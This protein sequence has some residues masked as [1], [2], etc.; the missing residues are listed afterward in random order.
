MKQTQENKI[1]ILTLVFLATS[2]LPLWSQL[3]LNKVPFSESSYYYG[4][5]N[6][7][8]ANQYFNLVDFYPSLRPQTTAADF[9]KISTDLRL[10]RPGSEKKLSAFMIDNPT[11]YLTETAYYDLAS[12]YFLN[13]KYTYALKWFSKIK[14]TDVASTKRNEYYFN[15]AYTL[16]TIKRFKE[17]EQLFQKIENVPKYQYDVS[18]YLGY[19]AY[20]LD[21]YDAAIENFNKVTTQ[22][23]D[24]TVGYFQADMNFNLGRFEK[25]IALARKSLINANENQTSELSKIIGESY[26]NLEDYRS[27]LP[28]LEVYKGKKG[29]WSNTDFYQLGYTYYRLGDYEKAIMQFNKIISGDD[30]VTQNAYYHLAD[31]YLKTDKK[32]E[33]LN[34]FKS[35]SSFKFDLVIKEDAFLNYARLSYE[36]GNAYENT[37]LVLSSFLDQYPKNKAV[38]EIE[39]LLIDS[40]VNSRNYDGA[41]K[42]LEKKTGSQYNG[43]LQK[44]NYMKAIALFRNGTFEESIT[45]FDRS[46]KKKI[47]PIIEANC[48]YWSALAK[49]ENNNFEEV[50]KDL[51]FF[52]RHPYAQKVS[53]FETLNYHIAYAYFKLKNYEAARN[54][55][56]QYL[57]GSTPNASYKRDSF[58]RMGD[59]DFVLGKYWPAMESYEKAIEL[60]TQKGMYALYQKALSYGFVDRN[61]KKIEALNRL[62]TDYP[63]TS[64]L[65]DTYFEL[66]SAYTRE[67]NT[68]QAIK[69]YDFLINNFPKSP[70]RSR[71]FLNKGLILYNS[72]S[73]EESMLV[74]Q[75]L[76]LEYP[77]EEVARQALKT[78]KEI[79][80]DLA[81]V[82]VFASWVKQLDGV[83]IEENEL[84]RASFRSAERLFNEN[85]KKAALKAFSSYL[86]QYPNGANQLQAQFLFAELNFQDAK[87]ESAV[88]FYKRVIDQPTN[89]YSEQSLVRIT[90]ALV[91][92]ELAPSALRY[93]KTLE[94]IAQFDENKRYALFNLMQLYYE[95][96]EFLEAITYA[97]KI[98]QLKSLVPKIKWDAYRVLAR[99]AVVL[100]DS[101]KASEAYAVLENA[102]D[103]ALAVEALY[104]NAKQK[105]LI[106]DYEGSNQLIEKIAK[107][108]GNFPEWNAK[109]LL[110]MS[111]NFYQL[112][113]AFQASFILESIL[114]NFTQFPKIIKQAQSDLDNIKAIEAQNNSSI[115]VKEENEKN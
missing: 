82:D 21:D 40:Y 73:L 105:H 35:A 29:R 108:F 20:Q 45:F 19:I 14:D 75:K 61:L 2:F 16:F 43:A 11:S 13:G 24:T 15:K 110:L 104:F 50:I 74:L 64:L 95:Q 33:A 28:Y 98:L 63:K 54:S 99:S 59:S 44:L 103:A 106:Y 83:T 48:L 89:E 97:Q 88:E 57:Q 84:E 6:F 111:Q 70:Y 76:V 80:I 55:F 17:A 23:G 49:Y 113:D 51:K 114:T 67:K 26:F 77:N 62:I 72:E 7:A 81:T 47:D 38:T 65:D 25:A 109:S 41:L 5:D 53:G 86:N 112:D 100:K 71:S 90:Q 9:Y 87:W 96:E 46:L 52:K 37:S 30:A 107:D 8:Q 115:N 79:S 39:K 69:T 92:N 1:T 101:K 4:S 85:K 93:W 32:T 12:Y 36:I 10:N 42:I 27:A 66:A 34:A 22:K 31:C 94:D 91:N 78:A 58:L 18:Y 102:P 3:G 68:D 60:D 56:E